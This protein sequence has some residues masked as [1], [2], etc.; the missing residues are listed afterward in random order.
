VCKCVCVCVCAP[1]CCGHSRVHSFLT[2]AHTQAAP[3]TSLHVLFVRL[4]AYHEASRVRS[5][6]D[7][8]GRRHS[9]T[10]VRAH[11]MTHHKAPSHVYAIS[12][13]CKIISGPSRSTAC[14]HGTLCSAGACVRHGSEALAWVYAHVGCRPAEH[15]GTLGEEEKQVIA[16]LL[17]RR[18]HLSQQERQVGPSVCLSACLYLYWCL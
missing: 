1:E 14:M 10:H 16:R 8:D 4:P 7:E 2:I 13:K 5:G 18:E 17:A 9:I 3:E 11:D 15:D 6:S 12:H